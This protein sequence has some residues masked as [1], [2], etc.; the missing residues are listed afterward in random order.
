MFLLTIIPFLTVFAQSGQEKLFIEELNKNEAYDFKGGAE[1]SPGNIFITIKSDIPDLF[2]DS[3]YMDIK[4]PEFDSIKKEYV[5][6]HENSSFWLTISS[7]KYLSEKIYI[8]GFSSKYAFKIVKK[9]PKGN[10]FFK[11]Y[12]NNAFVDFGFVGQRPQLSSATIEINAGEYKVKISKDGYETIDTTVLI[13]SDGSTKVLEISLKPVFAKLQLDI[14]TDDKSQPQIYPVIN[15]DSARISMT[16]MFDKTKIKSFDDLGNVEF[17][18]IYSGGVIPVPEGY[19]RILISTTGYKPYNKELISRK[20]AF[21]LIHAQLE[22]ISGFITVADMGNAMDAKVYLDNNFIGNVPVFKYKATVGNH[23]VK[24]VKDGFKTENEDFPVLIREDQEETLNIGMKIFKQY[25]LKTNPTGAEILVNNQ[26]QGFSPYDIFLYEGKNEVVVKKKGYLGVS[27]IFTID[28]TVKNSIDTLEYVLESTFPIKIESESDSM[29]V[30][31]SRKGE[32]ISDKFKTPVV[33]EI[34]YGNYRLSLFDDKRKVFSGTF[35]HDGKTNVNAPCYSRGTFVTLDAEYYLQSLPAYCDENFQ[36]I[37]YYNLFASGSFG[38][39]NLFPGLST[40]VL[41]ANVFKVNS[42]FEGEV[43]DSDINADEYKYNDY[44]FS[45]SCVFLNGEF[46]FGGSI[47]KKIDINAFGNFSWYPDI[48]KI[49]QKNNISGYDYSYGIELSTRFSFFNFKIKYG[50]YL[51]NGKFNILMDDVYNANFLISK[52]FS[53]NS[54]FVSIG[55]N[56]GQRNGLNNRMLRFWKKPLIS[57][58]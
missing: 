50:H 47:T 22:P 41:K 1:C 33:L 51:N 27:Q 5:F 29:S 9:A 8:D 28:N 3:N 21:D 45:G 40:T 17:F 23:K 32:L 19:H 14:F 44:L 55:F 48:T 20:G 6:C 16:E 25:R 43:I 38:K 53:I 18:K 46:L 26:R 37:N 42:L 31:V 57:K 4:K 54:N 36:S 2:F 56:L 35:R 11:T 58:F 15:I 7:P 13:P 24:I 34:P 30:V 52:P 39:F 10:I 12:P 49:I